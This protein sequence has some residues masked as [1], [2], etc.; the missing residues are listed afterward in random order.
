MGLMQGALERV[1]IVD[2]RFEKVIAVKQR[3]HRS[4]VNLYSAACKELGLA[5]DFGTSNVA[6]SSQTYLHTAVNESGMTVAEIKE[7]IEK[8]NLLK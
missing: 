6:S 4:W 2:N 1:A 8:R 3:S 5:Y 7:E